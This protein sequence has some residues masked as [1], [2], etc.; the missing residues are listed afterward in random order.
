MLSIFF[1]FVVETTEKTM[2]KI[3][4]HVTSKFTHF[5]CLSSLKDTIQAIEPNFD[6]IMMFRPIL[7]R[8]PQVVS[9]LF[10]NLQITLYTYHDDDFLDMYG[11]TLFGCTG[12]MGVNSFISANCKIT[13]LPNAKNQISN[14]MML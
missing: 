8:L 13:C 12:G 3:Y 5:M 7:L 9:H 2:S 6:L 4:N 1:S 14:S 10:M 11:I